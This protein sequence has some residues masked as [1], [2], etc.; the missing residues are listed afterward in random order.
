MSVNIM[1]RQT[2]SSWANLLPDLLL[3]I[4]NRLDVTTSIR[5]AAVC[6]SWASTLRPCLPSFPPICHDQPI[7]WLLCSARK[8]D[9]NPN[10]SVL[11][12]Y[13]L[14]TA[15]YFYVRIPIPL[16]CEHHWVGSYK[17]W[18]VTLDP[19]L[20]LHLIKPLTGAHVL[21]PSKGIEKEQPKK[22]ILWHN[23]N[24]TNE[25]R[26]FCLTQQGRLASARLGDESW[27]WMNNYNGKY[28]DII[29]YQ[30]KLYAVSLYVLC[31]WN[32]QSSSTEGTV[33]TGYLTWGTKHLLEWNSE[34]IML[35]MNNYERT[36]L[37]IQ[38]PKLVRL[39][40]AHLGD[41]SYSLNSVSSLDDDA[42][43]FGANCSYAVSSSGR[44]DIQGNFI[45]FTNQMSR[46]FH[47][48]ETF[49]PNHNF[50]RFDLGKRTYYKPCCPQDLPMDLPPPIWFWPC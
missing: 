10:Y 13:D 25:L 26:A 50:G 29:V 27:T 49:H 23:P 15:I 37:E 34:L 40:K 35:T 41:Y 11:T 36:S 18:L 16:L 6:T 8:S 32:L 42:L 44:D 9:A 47:D 46:C 5:L 7:P 39:Y 22:V 3:S 43:F 4:A 19:Q 14:S 48:S 21:L 24:N 20:Q 1:S 31:Y 2:S 28:T 33:I 30:E 17:G 12:F 38:A 45:Y